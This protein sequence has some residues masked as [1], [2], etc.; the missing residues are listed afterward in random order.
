MH[1]EGK[2]CTCGSQRRR[3]AGRE[4]GAT[5]LSALAVR[6]LEQQQRRLEAHPR[7]THQVLQQVEGRAAATSRRRR[8]GLRVRRV[9]ERRHGAQAPHEGGK[10]LGRV[11]LDHLQTPA[12]TQSCRHQQHASIGDTPVWCAEHHVPRQ[13]HYPPVPE[14]KV[15]QVG[16][17]DV[18]RPLLARLPACRA[19][20]AM[21][22]T[23]CCSAHE[24]SHGPH[25]TRT[26]GEGTQGAL[27]GGCR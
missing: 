1:R 13:P 7:C 27:T 9:P 20:P 17:N 14:L 24:A 5:A 22:H 10:A 16:A 2:E 12:R 26:R 15:M 6:P 19:R 4:G 8:R 18:Q 11:R 23:T 21:R 3:R 25:A